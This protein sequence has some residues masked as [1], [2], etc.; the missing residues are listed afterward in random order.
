MADSFDACSSDSAGVV[1][2]VSPL[3]SD[4]NDGRCAEPGESFVGPLATLEAARDAIRS[5]RARGG[6]GPYEVQLRGGWYFLPQPFVLEP[7]DSGTEQAD[8]VYRAYPGEK[9]ILSG[10]VLLTGFRDAQVNGHDGWVCEALPPKPFSQLFVNGQRMLRPRTPRQGW[11]RMAGCD[12][13]WVQGEGWYQ[14]ID[15]FNYA[16]GDIDPTWRN[17]E[18]VEVIILKR[19]FDS[20]TKIKHIDPERRKVTLDREMIE[21]P[22]EGGGEYARYWV[23]N[24]YE[25]MDQ[26][27]DFY[28]DRA[29][30]KLYYLPRFADKPETA[31]VIA[32]QLNTLVSFQGDPFGEK[33]KHVRF[34]QLDFRHAEYACPPG[35]PG[36][37]QAAFRVPGA[38]TFQGAEHCT[39]YGCSVSQV[40]QYAVEFR[41]GCTQNQVIACH[42]HDLGAGGVKVNHE[43]GCSTPAHEDAV[44]PLAN[45]EY[46]LVVPK[47]EDADALPPQRL[48]ISDCEIHD[49]GQ[50]FL[51]AVGIY[52]GDSGGNRIVHNHIH[53]MNYSGISCGWTWTFDYDTRTTD[54]RIEGNYIHHINQE[55]FISDL[56]GIY[57]LG[58]SP[59]SVL[60]GNL[61]HD[62]SSAVY[63]DWGIYFD[64]TSSYIQA[65]GNA[66]FRCGYGA[67]FTNIARQVV[68][69][70]NI[71]INDQ[72][73]DN[74][75]VVI[76]EDSGMLTAV[77]EDNVLVSDAPQVL[78]FETYQGH[79]RFGGNTY[80]NTHERYG[81]AAR[82]FI[83]DMLSLEQ[84]L[85]SDMA[86]DESVGGYAITGT[87][88]GQLHLPNNAAFMDDTWRCILNELRTA[89]PR[90]A[91][92]PLVS[93]EQWPRETWP[94]KPILMPMFEFDFPFYTGLDSCVPQLQVPTGESL[95]GQVRVV[96]RGWV[97]VDDEIVIELEQ[98]EQGELQGD[99]RTPVHLLPG[100][101][102]VLNYKVSLTGPS[103]RSLLWVRSSTDHAFHPVGLF[104]YPASG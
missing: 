4:Q 55:G 73:P 56:A 67:M 9:P 16:E 84:W 96:N 26:P 76:G 80:C 93:Y 43:R 27:G 41:L 17:I 104:L 82:P 88:S 95:S 29:L 18:D 31:Q 53:R 11:S 60:R 62:V 100:E 46:G 71:L 34:E 98:P 15:V 36:S 69:R 20:H 74:P 103:E 101:E 40:A 21:S 59:G 63:G 35:D 64:G 48:V 68:A 12:K 85:N 66:A 6:T 7:Q 32:P 1:I 83:G 58:P 30:G 91:A 50:I 47:G 28:H 2:Y 99:V 19:W 92:L 57:T 90:S 49:G 54:N 25:H 89:G 8:V 61:I 38:I 75:A 13:Q 45:P 23:E 81:F 33:V 37:I 77:L 42:L 65:E 102:R 79:V 51:S 70:R 72:S 97:P 39:L 44:R 24:V 78:L 3:G 52:I 94:D 5:D 22:E 14:G 10:G 87:A 86:S